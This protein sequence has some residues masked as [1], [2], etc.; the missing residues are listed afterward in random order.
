M[1][2]VS[3]S[4]KGRRRGGE[5]GNRGG[6][7][8]HFFAAFAPERKGGREEKKEQTGPFRFGHRARSLPSTLCT[9]GKEKKERKE[10]GNENFHVV[11]M[12]LSM[13]R[14]E[15]EG[16][17]RG[18]EKG[19]EGGATD[20]PVEASH[21]TVSWHHEG[22]KRGGGDSPTTPLNFHQYRS[23]LEREKGGGRGKGRR[24]KGKEEKK[25]DVVA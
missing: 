11:S 3:I 14:E 24:G 6:A 15:G 5:R 21:L 23:S 4:G 2:L 1:H 12:Y 22:E 8:G 16:G 7:E 19:E 9:I 25:G 17:E 20:Q 10:G 18:G 13:R